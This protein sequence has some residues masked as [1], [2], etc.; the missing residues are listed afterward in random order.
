MNKNKLKDLIEYIGTMKV[1]KPWGEIDSK[2][3]YCWLGKL[4]KK[5]IY[6]QTNE[7]RKEK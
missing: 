3:L 1:L 5:F 7:N 2:Y 4:K 6:D